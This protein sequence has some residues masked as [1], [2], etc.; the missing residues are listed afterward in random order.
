MEN[1]RPV[2]ALVRYMIIQAARDGEIQLVNQPHEKLRQDIIRWM[3]DLAKSEWQAAIQSEHQPTLIQ[4]AMRFVDEDEVELAIVMYAT[5]VE[6]WLNGMLEIGLK[7]RG[8]Q[9]DQTTERGSL[10]HKLTTRWP[11]LLGVE[12]PDKLQH[13]ILA[14]ARA[15][16]N[17]VHY[18]WPT[19]S[20]YQHDTHLTRTTVIARDAPQILAA[21]RDLEDSIVFNGE[22]ERLD[23]ILD[24]M[25]LFDVR[26]PDSADESA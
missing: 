23:R 21:L 22:R 5:A 19:H 24:E 9:L 13:S 10:E 8:E 14:L 20:E 7:R 2:I 3:H 1:D 25:E 16:N 4:A 17:F 15:R 12:F 18:K 11:E 26:A 6:H